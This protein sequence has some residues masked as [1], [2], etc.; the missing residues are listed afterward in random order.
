MDLEAKKRQSA[1]HLS[2]PPPRE[3]E[4]REI[5]W[6]VPKYN[7]KFE[8]MWVNK[9]KV[10][11]E[12]VKFEIYYCGICYTDVHFV[13]NDL[14]GSTYPIVPGHE[15]VGKVVEVG[16][17]VTKCKVGD[18]VGVGCIIDACLKCPS[19]KEDKA[20][21]FCTG[22]RMTHTYNTMKNKITGH[23][24]GNPEVQNFGGYSASQVV[25]EH[26]I[27]RVP[28][29]LPMEATGPLLCAGITMYD[30]LKH[31]GALE[32]KK[33]MTIGVIGI[34]GLGTMGIKMARAMGHKVVAIS[35]SD[36]QE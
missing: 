34:G 25:H 30:P 6:G 23:F 14:C 1:K 3:D 33:K 2:I 9:G 26:F 32:S 20:E 8:P 36:R 24:V 15:L 19:C 11:D 28:K 29:N 16:A 27:I 22:P 21:Q 12:Y 5:A 17:K 10:Q 18:I 31:W 7:G 35:V 13:N 4:Y